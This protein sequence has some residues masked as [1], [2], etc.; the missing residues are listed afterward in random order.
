MNDLEKDY[1][2]NN[3]DAI[4]E[5]FFAYQTPNRCKNLKVPKSLVN[6]MRFSLNCAEN[7]NLEY[8]EDYKFLS[9][10]DIF[11]VNDMFKKYIKE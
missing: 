4:F 8:L 10:W 6:L 5:S 11:T 7:L 9:H 1:G 2:I 3:F